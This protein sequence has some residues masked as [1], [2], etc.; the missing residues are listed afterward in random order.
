MTVLSVAWYFSSSAPVLYGLTSS[1]CYHPWTKADWRSKKGNSRKDYLEQDTDI[2][3]LKE[4][5]AWVMDGG[6]EV[7]EWIFN[8]EGFWFWGSFFLVTGTDLKWMKLKLQASHLHET[9][10]RPW[11]RFYKFLSIILCFFFL[12]R[13][14]PSLTLYK[15]QAPQSLVSFLLF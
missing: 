11:E 2:Q 14:F 12:K 15:L 13:K 1:F 3:E 6:R 10:P 8:I 7:R 4:E 5:S 9:L